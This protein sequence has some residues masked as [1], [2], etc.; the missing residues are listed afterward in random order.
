MYIC[1]CPAEHG[2]PH[3]KKDCKLD[4]LIHLCDTSLFCSK[5]FPERNPL[6]RGSR[7]EAL[8]F[9]SRNRFGDPKHLGRP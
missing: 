1:I 3:I 9:G 2:F 5:G 4:L 7:G 8:G 6:R